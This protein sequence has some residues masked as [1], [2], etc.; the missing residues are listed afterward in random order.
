MSTLVWFIADR[1]L[2][3]RM[4][5]EIDTSE[6]INLTPFLQTQEGRGVP[7]CRS[8]EGKLN[9]VNEERQNAKSG[10]YYA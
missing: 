4:E 10:S 9:K 3:A 5:D 8:P 1:I 7:R 2:L 6:T